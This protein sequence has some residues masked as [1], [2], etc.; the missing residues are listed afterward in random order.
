MHTQW[1]QQEKKASNW[2][3]QYEGI[4]FLWLLWHLILGSSCR[5]KLKLTIVIIDTLLLNNVRHLPQE[6]SRVAFYILWHG[7]PHLLNNCILCMQSIAWQCRYI[8]NISLTVKK[9]MRI[10][11]VT[12]LYSSKYDTCTSVYIHV[13]V[14]VQCVL[15]IKCSALYAC[16]ICHVHVHHDHVHDINISAE[17]LQATL[18]SWQESV[19]EAEK[20]TQQVRGHP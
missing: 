5:S 11:A 3:F 10:T 16:W 2:R 20:I 6:F 13:H 15:H 12:D 4:S 19:A 14:H 18:N 8:W 9:R 17:N 1:Q 7:R